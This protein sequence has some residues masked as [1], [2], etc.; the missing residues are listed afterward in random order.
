MFS[1]MVKRWLSSLRDAAWRRNLMRSGMV[2]ALLIAGVLIGLTV[3]YRAHLQGNFHKLK[4]KA[5]I[6]SE[7]QDAPVPRPGG[8]EPIVL[9]RSRMTGDRGPEFLSAMLLPG[10]GMNVLQI[11]A[12]IPG[13][14]EVKL[15][16]SPPIESAA[17]EMTGRGADANGEASL[18]MGGAFELP[19]G[20]TLGGTTSDRSGTVKTSWQGEQIT[21]PAGA[22]NGWMLGRGADTVDSE[23]LPDGGDA[24]ADFQTG[25]FDGRWASKT[26]VT[27][28]ALLSSQ[29][30]ELTVVAKNTG[31]VVEP[32][33]V[34]WR[35]RIAID[36]G[37]RAQMRLQIPAESK[38]AMRANGHASGELIAGTSDDFTAQGGASLGTRSVDEYFVG[39]KQ[40]LLDNGPA[41]ELSDPASGYGLRITALSP[42]IRAMHV[43]APADGDFITIDPQYNYPDPFGGQWS[44]E[45]HTGMVM[46]QPGQTTEWK[47]RLELY[48]LGGDTSAK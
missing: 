10:R 47:I 43:I 48:M 27:I 31:D 8:Q 40:K 38:L 37:N 41:A 15:L 46:L 18:A 21:F 35:P 16:A 28:S 5:N 9:V 12:Y 6:E 39:L 2:T 33:G 11:T 22:K 36:R 13:K 23:T 44:S 20:G 14:G 3:A 17:A 30:V 19:W 42:T 25:D 26:D 32:I 7:R 4:L 29:A 45:T 34:G 1:A 24:Q